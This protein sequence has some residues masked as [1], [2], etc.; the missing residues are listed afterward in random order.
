MAP[1]SKAGGPTSRKMRSLSPVRIHS[2]RA[3]IGLRFSFAQTHD[4][5]IG[6][7]ALQCLP[8][9]TCPAPFGQVAEW[10]PPHDEGR[11]DPRSRGAAASLGEIHVAPKV[12]AVA[13]RALTRKVARS[14]QSP[15]RRCRPPPR[16]RKRRRIIDGPRLVL[17]RECGCAPVCT[18]KSVAPGASTTTGDEERLPARRR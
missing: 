2:P 15:I 6:A 8:K 9:S 12:V 18:Y 3:Q 11:M 13:S 7:C 10:L 4:A 17:R 16:Q 1:G 14:T 5:C